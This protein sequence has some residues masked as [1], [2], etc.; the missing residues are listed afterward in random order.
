M[1]LL[2]V[3]LERVPWLVILE[4]MQYGDLKKVLQTCKQ[5][6]VVVS[7]DEMLNYAQQVCAGLRFVAEK[8]SRR[9]R[10]GLMDV[11]CP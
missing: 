4:L 2:G 6:G 1:R 11:C 7:K 8:V 10:G 3:G 9:V 5:R